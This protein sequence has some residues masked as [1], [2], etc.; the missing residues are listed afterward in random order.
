M[1]IQITDWVEN[2]VGNEEIAHY[3]QFLHFPKCFQKLSADDASKWVSRSKG[4][5][6]AIIVL[7]YLLDHIWD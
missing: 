6:H 5:M 1:G 3:E 2:I 4:L 7:I